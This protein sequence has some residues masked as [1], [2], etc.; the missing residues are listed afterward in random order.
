MKK[1]EAQAEYQRELEHRKKVQERLGVASE[2]GYF[3]QALADYAHVGAVK[4]VTEV[5][6]VKETAKLEARVCDLERMMAEAGKKLWPEHP[7][8]CDCLICDPDPPDD[9]GEK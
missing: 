5:R 1:K 3:F 2:G 6:M 4:P 8:N 7:A 9:A